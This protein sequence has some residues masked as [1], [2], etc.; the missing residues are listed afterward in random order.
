MLSPDICARALDARDSRFDGLFFVGI[1]TTGIYCRPVCPARVSYPERRRF[2]ETAASAERA[3]FR[4]CLRCRPELAPGRALVD[5]VPRLARVAAHRIEAGALNG[6]GVGAL[7]AE[8]GVSERHLRRALDRELGVSPIELAQTHRLLLAKRLLAD[9][10]LPVTRI[11]FA[12]GFQSLRRFN[13]VFRERYRLSPTALRRSPGPARER[14]SGELIRLTL[15]YRPPFNWQALLESL[16]ESALPGV[17]QIA[18][19]SYARTV[20]LDGHSGVVVVNHAPDRIQLDVDISTGLLPVLMPLLARLRQLFDLDADPI[21]IESTLEQH[22]LASCVRERP[23][24]RLPGALDGFEAAVTAL[25]PPDLRGRLVEELGESGESP[26]S[27]LTWLSPDAHSIAGAGTTRLVDLGLPYERARALVDVAR[28]V[29]DC[30]IR[31]EA[32]SDAM[33]THSAL[34]A[35]SGITDELATSIIARALHWPDAFPPADSELE[36]RAEEWRPWRAYAALHLGLLGSQA[37]DV[38]TASPGASRR[39]P[40][41]AGVLGTNAHGEATMARPPDFGAGGRQRGERAAEPKPFTE[42]IHPL[43]G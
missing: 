39:R 15:G 9:T 12:S 29:L 35:I 3:G 10:S 18:D 4:P 21:G 40:V 8:L 33:A 24:L 13:A 42:L 17:E 37:A 36:Q 11:A 6:S 38:C 27:A 30:S 34:L 41:S 14:P 26:L 16:A 22:G 23:G 31:L 43:R 28:A 2:F 20:K 5:A 25:V 19:G 1:T 7:A 32:G